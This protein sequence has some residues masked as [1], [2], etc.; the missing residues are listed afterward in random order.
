MVVNELLVMIG[1]DV[2][3]VVVPLLAGVV[4]VLLLL[5]EVVRE[6]ELEDVEVVMFCEAVDEV[7]V[8][9]VE[10]VLGT[11]VSVEDAE[12]DETV[13]AEVKELDVTGLE[14]EL[15]LELEVVRLEVVRLEVTRLEVTR[16]EVVG[17]IVDPE[18]ITED[19]AEALVVM[20]VSLFAL[21]PCRG[22]AAAELARAAVRKANEKSILSPY[23]W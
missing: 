1:F 12:V 18:A 14:L 19:A 3:E 16:L 5:L 8:D 17:K 7:K 21:R 11:D 20:T 15:I 2:V 9:I 13:E 4:V 6:L 10:L 22:K 23:Y